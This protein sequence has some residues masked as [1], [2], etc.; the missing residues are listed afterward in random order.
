MQLSLQHETAFRLKIFQNKSLITEQ[1]CLDL[2]AS[3]GTCWYKTHPA[4]HK[5]TLS[6][7]HNMN[8]CGQ[9]L[10]STSTILEILAYWADNKCHVWKSSNQITEWTICLGKIVN[11]M[12]RWS[13]SVFNIKLYS[14]DTL[15]RNL[16][17]TVEYILNW[18]LADIT[19][20]ISY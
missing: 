2:W 14:S 16:E 13:W 15:R 3:T 19:S 9:V 8:I 17:L 4:N 18:C 12:A 6:I 20:Q 11:F 5:R 1:P 7:C 10:S